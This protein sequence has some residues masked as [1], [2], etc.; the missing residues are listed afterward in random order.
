[1]STRRLE[2]FGGNALAYLGYLYLKVTK[3]PV[4]DLI[5]QLEGQVA[6][7]HGVQPRVPSHRSVQSEEDEGQTQRQHDSRVGNP[8]RSQFIEPK[9]SPSLHIELWNPTTEYKPAQS[10]PANREWERRTA[11]FFNNLPVSEEQWCQKRQTAQLYTADDVF[12]T[13]D[14]LVAGSLDP[15]RNDKC[16]SAEKSAFLVA[17]GDQGSVDALS[18]SAERAAALI[19]TA[20]HSKH[21]AQ[22]FSLVFMAECRVALFNG[23][24]ETSVYSAIRKFVEASGGKCNGDKTPALLLSTTLWVLQ[25]QQRQFRRG[26]LHRGFELFFNEGTSLDFYIRC[27][28]EPTSNARFTAKIPICEVPDE[29]QASLPLWLPFIVGIRNINQYS[30]TTICTAL[31]V[32]LWSRDEDFQKWRDTYLSRTLVICHIKVDCPESELSRKLKTRQHHAKKRKRSP[33]PK[34]RTLRPNSIHRQES[35]FRATGAGQHGEPVFS[36]HDTSLAIR[37]SSTLEG[38]AETAPHSSQG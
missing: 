6:G 4:A 23:C 10:S 20:E 7:L 1:M 32:T 26:L 33:E 3:V 14:C 25:E 38:E 15:L 24:S 31:D 12:R 28:K 37:D 22:F 19:A 21:V 2:D 8:R 5:S 13:V 27:P 18:S 36:R 30:Y 16:S 29:I 35:Q 17:A 9:D 34:N 11:T